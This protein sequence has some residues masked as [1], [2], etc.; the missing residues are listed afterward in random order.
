M[1]EANDMT[2][3]PYSCCVPAAARARREKAQVSGVRAVRVSVQR[4]R[5]AREGVG[6]TLRA[7]PRLRAPIGASQRCEGASRRG[8][9]AGVRP[10]QAH[11]FQRRG[12]EFG[13]PTAAPQAATC[14]ARRGRER[15]EV[16][17]RARLRRHLGNR[18]MDL[19][20]CRT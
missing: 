13:W 15:V 10:A 3:S 18:S 16:D 17:E 7:Q 19:R 5:P 6:L 9:D 2:A 12:G 4:E 20:A 8:K 14:A 1:C 11:I